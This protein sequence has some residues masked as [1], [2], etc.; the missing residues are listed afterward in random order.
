MI[1]RRAEQL[2]E[3]ISAINGP[4]DLSTW[5]SFFQFDFMGDMAFGGGFE[6][7]RDGGDEEGIHQILRD[8][9][10]VFALTSHVPWVSRTLVHLPVLPE[11]VTKLFTFGAE[12]SSKRIKN[13]SLKKDLWY[14]LTDEAG[15]EAEKPAL[16]NVIPDGMLAIAAGGDTTARAIQNLFFAILSHP[17]YYQRLKDELE[18]VFP[19]GD[20]ILDVGK[21]TELKFLDALI[22][23][24]LRLYPPVP[25]NGPRQ[26]SDASKARVICNEFVPEG[27]VIY[28]PPYV[29]HRDARYFS[30]SP[31]KF[32]PERWMTREKVPN[33]AK[34]QAAASESVLNTVAY[35]PFSFGP[36]NCVGRNLAKN[37]IKMV[38]A[39]LL[40]RFDFRFADGFDKEA[41]ED[42]LC[43]YF[44]MHPN[45]HLL[46]TLTKRD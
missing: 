8:Y 13:G 45:K 39:L 17:A 5:L 18:I 26:V 27:T 41:W 22:N 40:S 1:T 12:R 20:G 10:R 14:H 29:L 32:I 28:I 4:V 9:L 43:D 6:M 34:S 33:D 3:K 7:L 42:S 2:I 15:L 25:T 46:V 24:T 11:R 23:E 19:S 37:E 21:Y 44:I 38:V 31:N 35:I 30:P 36:Q 16:S